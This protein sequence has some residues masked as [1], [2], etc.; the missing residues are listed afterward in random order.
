MFDET[1]FDWVL[2]WVLA[3][4]AV[5]SALFVVVGRS[6]V[7]RHRWHAGTV[8][9][10][11]DGAHAGWFHRDGADSR[12][13]L[14]VVIVLFH[15]HADGSEG[16]AVSRREGGPASALAVSLCLA[17]F[18]GWRYRRQRVAGASP[19]PALTEVREL[20]ICCSRRIFFR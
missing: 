17:V 7:A 9:R 12:I 15:H 18:T 2:F 3:V 20:G 16:G 1:F 10:R 4:G 13:R 11:S 6:P 19:P 14:Q 5:G 8:R